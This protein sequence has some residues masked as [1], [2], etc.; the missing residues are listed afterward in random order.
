MNLVSSAVPFVPTQ[1]AGAVFDLDGTLIR[2]E[3]ILPGAVRLLDHFRDRFVLASNN[4]SDT[5][6]TLSA[7]LAQMG[8]YIPEDRI[9]LA[10]EELLRLM[11][12]Q[13]PG[14]RVQLLASSILRQRARELGLQLVDADCDM[15]LVCRDACFGYAK[16][17]SAANAVRDG[18]RLIAANPDLTHPG[19]GG[20]RVPETGSL[21]VAI[22]ACSSKQADQIIGKPE[23]HL[24]VRSLE[25]LGITADQSIMVGDNPAT[26]GVGASGCRIPFVLIGSH[27]DAVA[28]YPADLLEAW[29]E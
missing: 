14:A 1:A 4:S 19:K 13:Y 23:P 6:R 7:Q 27:R 2:E 11:A 29:G 18:A 8:L 24:F 16:L 20:E 9:V 3:E 28:R 25:R 22:E 10:G 17:R 26:D 15:V 21:L 12:V 5:A